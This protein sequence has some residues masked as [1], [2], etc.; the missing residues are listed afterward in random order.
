MRR[1]I[2]IGTIVIAAAM[3][4]T[5]IVALGYLDRASREEAQ[6]ELFRQA[7]VTGS[8][9]D[10]EVSGVDL[11][12]GGD[13][14]ERFQ[15]LRGAVALIL[16]RARV[17]G[18]HDIVEASLIVRDRTIPL[19]PNQRLMGQLPGDLAEQEVLTLEVDG[20]EM[21]ATVQRIPVSNAEI[22][23][24]IG[25]TAPLLP[26]RAMSRTLLVTIAVG[27][28]L[29]VVFGLW[30][31]GWVGRRLSGLSAASRSIASGDMTARAPV[32]GDDEVAEASRSFNDMANALE[33]SRIRDRDFLL[34][35]GHDLRTPLTTIR[36]YAEALDAGTIDADDTA[37]VASVL[38][39]QTDRLSRLVED[40]M[41]LARIEAREFTLRPESIDAVGLVGG[42]VD[43]FRRR[44]DEV[45]VEIEFIAGV[46]GAATVDPDRLDQVCSNLIENALRYTPE[47]GTVTIE[48]GVE[49]GRFLLVV[50]DTGP[51]IEAAD[52]K[53]VFDRL[54]V[55]QR[56]RPLRPEGSGLGLTIVRELTTAMGGSVVA[57]SEPGD[58]S[59]FT[60]DLPAEQVASSK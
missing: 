26:T 35:I 30:M 23:V 22:V 10:S 56:Y 1:R 25:R 59:Q 4:L 51:G 20:S 16:N 57:A 6:L 8:L 32:E 37:R 31:A 27:V 17:V 18:G 44:S 2:V 13:I 38:H 34:S 36:G 28:V 48:A 41:L 21:F 45:G 55:T 42:V 47:H 46:D 52:L 24:A 14:E 58:G 15:R 5:G 3:L 11:A 39:T 54:Y 9:I 19:S 7:E 50:S 60:V 49:E 12:P 43:G 29:I 33:T 53:K 40:V